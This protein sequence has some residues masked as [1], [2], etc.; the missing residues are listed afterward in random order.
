MLNNISMGAPTPAGTGTGATYNIRVNQDFSGIRVSSNV[1]FEKM[2][3]K[4][5]KEMVKEAVTEI[6]KQLG[7][8]RT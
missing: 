1:D 2:L 7:L 3:K 8:R 6:K 5:N 4:S